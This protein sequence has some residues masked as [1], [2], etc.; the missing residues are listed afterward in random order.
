MT[1]RQQGRSRQEQRLE[2]PPLIPGSGY[3][4]DLDGAAP[5]PFQ[6]ERRAVPQLDCGALPREF[7]VPLITSV[8]GM[9]SQPPLVIL[10]TTS[11]Q[12]GTLPMRSGAD[13]P[14]GSGLRKFTLIA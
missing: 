4:V 12:T 8:L 6:S 14:V 9:L 13:T 10:P 2:F 1:R 5:L 3:A 7:P 11:R